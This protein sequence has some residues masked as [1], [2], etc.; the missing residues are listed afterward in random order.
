MPGQDFPPGI[1]PG[2]EASPDID[3]SVA[4]PATGYDLVPPGLVP[5]DRRRPGPGGTG[6]GRRSTAHGGVAPKYAAAATSDSV[7]A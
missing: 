3:T 1:S 6:T 2:R 4:Y 5:L 7:G